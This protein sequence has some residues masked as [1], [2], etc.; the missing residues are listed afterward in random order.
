MVWNDVLA[1]MRKDMRRPGSLPSGASSTL[2]A[3]RMRSAVEGACVASR[4]DTQAFNTTIQQVVKSS[5][6][7]DPALCGWQQAR[8][9][10]G[11]G[12][13]GH[14]CLLPQVSV[15]ILNCFQQFPHL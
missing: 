2:S 15:Q 9:D 1:L 4:V 11:R 10:A 14:A 6:Y 3:L 12:C 5:T 8:G 13:C 7:E